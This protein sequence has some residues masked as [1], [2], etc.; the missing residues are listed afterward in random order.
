MSLLPNS[1]AALL[2]MSAV[3]I[4]PASAMEPIVLQAP[5]SVDH[6]YGQEQASLNASAQQLK[7]QAAAD[8]SLKMLEQGPRHPGTSSLVTVGF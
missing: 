6:G 4:A 8:P 1:A 3:A 2:A 7:Q 5:T